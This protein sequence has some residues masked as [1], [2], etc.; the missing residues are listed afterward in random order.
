MSLNFYKSKIFIALAV[1]LG[2][3]GIS[4]SN[5]YAQ[6]SDGQGNL[7]QGTWADEADLFRD[8]DGYAG[9]DR[10]GRLI[11]VFGGL[12]ALGEQL[13]RLGVRTEN[14][15]A[16]TDT[17]R[18]LQN[19]DIRGLR[20]FDSFLPT[21][22]SAIV[23]IRE[24]PTDADNIISQYNAIF[25]T[26]YGASDGYITAR[27]LAGDKVT[28][29][30]D[31]K[32]DE[33]WQVSTV[34]NGKRQ[35]FIGLDIPKAYPT[36]LAI[37][38]RGNQAYRK[39]GINFYPQSPVWA[40]EPGNTLGWISPQTSLLA[41]LRSNLDKG[42][43]NVPITTVDVAEFNRNV[44]RLRIAVEGLY[45]LSSGDLLA[46]KV[47]MNSEKTYFDDPYVP[48]GQGLLEPDADVKTEITTGGYQDKRWQAD[49]AA[50]GYL[51]NREAG[52]PND[53]K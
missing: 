14:R 41:P 3:I 15:G 2:S 27:F 20:V 18:F 53:L 50:G 30:Y 22:A 21:T 28:V 36:A 1:C 47:D 12:D 24:S 11:G 26:V 49:N 25:K 4:Q 40:A 6:Q 16:F 23:G 9:F 39:L 37:A 17:L 7:Y 33:V 19:S 29:S 51:N 52:Q 34:F 13:R 8:G 44:N 45:R 48:A 32:N 5:V 42:G 43:F 46:P 10:L 31:S 35:I 38:N